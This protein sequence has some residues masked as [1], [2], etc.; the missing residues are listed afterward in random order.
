[1]LYNPDSQEQEGY[2]ALLQDDNFENNL[3]ITIA[4]TKIEAN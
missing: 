2:T 4:D 1:M 3:N